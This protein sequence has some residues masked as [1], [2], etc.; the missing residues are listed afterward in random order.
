MRAVRRF[1]SCNYA[2]TDPL[3]PH[4]NPL[5]STSVI[6]MQAKVLYESQ[7]GTGRA[8]RNQVLNTVTPAVSVYRQAVSQHGINSGQAATA[9]TN[10]T[11][12]VN[13]YHALP[14]EA[15][16]FNAGNKVKSM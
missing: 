8:S 9:R 7:Y 11:Q 3:P 13:A 16:A 15:D 10:M 5:I 6:G 2:G 12:S 4:S 14:E 1:G